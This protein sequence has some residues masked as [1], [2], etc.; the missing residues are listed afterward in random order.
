MPPG[1]GRPRGRRRRGWSC[2]TG[3]WKRCTGRCA[4]VFSG[5]VVVGNDVG[6]GVGGGL[7]LYVVV[8]VVVAALVLLLGG[9]GG[10]ATRW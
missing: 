3:E 4:G 9:V 8:V 10:G 5:M 6:V 1:G 7:E 2:P